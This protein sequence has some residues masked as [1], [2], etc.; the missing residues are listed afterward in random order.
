MKLNET[1]KQ[2][3]KG[4]HFCKEKCFA[5]LIWLSLCFLQTRLSQ[6]RFSTCANTVRLRNKYKGLLTNTMDA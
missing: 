5:S 2:V 3:R 4:P 1:L 6:I